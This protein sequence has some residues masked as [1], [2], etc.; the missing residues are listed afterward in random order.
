MTQLP[1][2]Q[3]HAV[4]GHKAQ[5]QTLEHIIISKLFDVGVRGLVSMPNDL[6]WFYTAVSRTKTRSGL[7]LDLRALPTDHIKT[8]RLD[9]LAEMA[10]LQVLHEETRV[11]VHT[12]Q[13]DQCGDMDTRTSS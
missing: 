13:D 8:R 2:S 1:I 7:T 3:A 4:S 9:V 12:A 6:G 10:R 5:G 11:R